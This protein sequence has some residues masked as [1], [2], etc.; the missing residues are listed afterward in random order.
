MGELSNH[1]A[2]VVPRIKKSYDQELFCLIS[3]LKGAA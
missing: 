2:A 3:L 1:A